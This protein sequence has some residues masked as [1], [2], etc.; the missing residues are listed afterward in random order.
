MDP[1]LVVRDDLYWLR[2]D[3]RNDSDVLAHLAAENAYANCSGAG[4]EGLAETIFDELVSAV[5]QADAS[6]PARSGGYIY[7]SRSVEGASYPLFVRRRILGRDVD[8]KVGGVTVPDNGQVTWT[9]GELGP[10]EV[11]L[12]VTALAGD[13]PYF[14]VRGVNVS[15]DHTLVTYAVDTTG[16]EVY[17]GRVRMIETGE[18]RPEDVV[19]RM[20]GGSIQ[21]GLDNR[22]LFYTTA[23]AT[24][25]PDKVW[26][27]TL[28]ARGEPS[29]SPAPAV[30]ELLLTEDDREYAA[31]FSISRSGR[32]LILASGS[33]NS[34][35][36]SLL[37]L[38][39][40]AAARAAGTTPPGPKLVAPRTLGLLYS[41]SHTGGDD[42][43]VVTNAGGA[44]NFKLAVATVGAPGP[45]NWTDAAPYNESVAITGVTPFERFAVL[46]ARRG[47]YTRLSVVAYAE[48]PSRA[49]NLSS[50]VELAFPEE[51][52]TVRLGAGAYESRAFHL[53]YTSMTTPT[54]TWAYDGVLHNR[55][56]L[57][58]QPVPGYNRSLYASERWEV[59]AADG[60]TIPVS[61]VYRT[62]L[63]AAAGKPQACHMYGYGSYGISVE[64][65]FSSSRLPLLDRGLVDVIA[66]V[67]GG[68]EMGWTWYEAAR[69]DSKNVTFSDFIAVGRA[70]VARNVTTPAN[71]SMEGASAGG[72]L[73]GAVLTMAPDLA[74]AG[75]MLVVPFVDALTGGGA[76]VVL[77]VDLEGGHFNPS[78]RFLSWRRQAAE[79][80]WLLA[81]HGKTA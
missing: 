53:S 28:S 45:A 62:D 18:E 38:Q 57:K 70:L 79:L 39:A 22:T 75:A 23:D 47:G 54:E 1:P 10:E 20:G 72:L 43:V 7:Y 31:G 42:L 51:A 64:P 63:R 80:A 4:E 78:D 49:L 40:D 33:S 69:L 48:G 81:R 24:Q 58:E 34:T 12:N 35:E 32:F 21:W 41:V 14:N 25:R 5:Q 37:D 17:E 61:V 74:G 59:E 13:A 67:R 15:P 46:S 71:L 8:G 55:T 60:A 44:A 66:H 50:A 11:F 26:R 56:L 3:A 19:P 68:G 73:V 76:D 30:D 29:S 77:R 65:S 2:D 27:R 36:Q 9:E 16:A 52:A 6:L